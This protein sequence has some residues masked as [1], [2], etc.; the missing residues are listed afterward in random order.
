MAIEKMSLVNLVGSLSELDDTLIRCCES[1]SFH[2]ENSIHSTQGAKG[3]EVLNE[4]NPYSN[5]LSKLVDL[6]IELSIPLGYTDFSGFSR[7]CSQIG[8]DAGKALAVFL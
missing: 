5:T 6:S 4:P 7:T 1:G 3:F 8:E 2:V